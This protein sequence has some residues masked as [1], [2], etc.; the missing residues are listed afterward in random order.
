[1]RALIDQGPFQPED[2]L[3]VGL[4]DEVAYEDELDDLVD[5]LRD[6]DYV[7]A[8]DYARC[9]GSDRRAARDRRSPSSM[10]PA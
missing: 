7:E 5:D 8:E 6:A 2:A 1:M 3:R 9:R 4:I 10:P